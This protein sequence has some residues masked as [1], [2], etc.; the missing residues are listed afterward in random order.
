M[1]PPGGESS[2]PADSGGRQKQTDKDG[3]LPAAV[4]SL[5]RP[6]YFSIS[7]VAV[8]VDLSFLSGP[9]PARPGWLVMNTV[10]RP[11]LLA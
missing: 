9:Y 7:S 1:P 11:T 3:C 6:T 5:M 8:T 2:L 10:A 4:L